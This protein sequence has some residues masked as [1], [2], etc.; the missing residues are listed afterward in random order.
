MGHSGKLLAV[1]GAAGILIALGVSFAIP[2]LYISQVVLL[3]EGPPTQEARVDAIQ[4]LAERAW[5]RIVLGRMIENFDLYA[6]DLYES[7]GGKSSLEDLVSKMRSQISTTPLNNR[8]TRDNGRGTTFAIGFEYGDPKVAQQVVADLE[9]RL[10]AENQ[11]GEELGIP[12]VD[13][14]IISPPSVPRYPA[15]PKRLLLAVE[16]LTA[17]LLAGAFL[18]F[19]RR[20]PRSAHTTGRR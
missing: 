17:G 13:L 10:I 1:T 16:G 7:K 5:P 2:N 18:A 14:K 9:R 4:S 19:R 20:R 3:V 15:S 11:H 6:S 12:G 8:D